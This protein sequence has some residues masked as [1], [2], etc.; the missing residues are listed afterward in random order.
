MKKS[1]TLYCVC[2]VAGVIFALPGL[3]LEGEEISTGADRSFRVEMNID[4]EVEEIN[5]PGWEGGAY[6]EPVGDGAVEFGLSF[7]PDGGFPT[8][9]VGRAKIN[10]YSCKGSAGCRC[11]APKELFS[12]VWTP[13]TLENIR[14]NP[15]QKTMI[16][17]GP[18]TYPP[19]MTM[20][21]VDCPG[22]SSS[23]EDHPL[24]KLLGA[25][26]PENKERKESGLSVSLAGEGPWTQT[27]SHELFNF[28]PKVFRAKVVL[29]IREGNLGACS[30][31]N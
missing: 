12:R 5:I 14:W 4:F 27:F 21:Q 25:L 6:S 24:Y 11:T 28:G 19:D 7:N 18:F 3:Q 9:Q 1:K 23:A 13:I 30:A 15:E 17:K 2:I 29:M 8:V 16:F 22:I 26:G 10:N 31:Q 20:I